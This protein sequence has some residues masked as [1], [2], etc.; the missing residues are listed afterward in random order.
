MVS[1]VRKAEL[2]NK[3]AA[4][5]REI[6]YPDTTNLI[7][8]CSAESGYAEVGDTMLGIPIYTVPYLDIRG[9]LLL[10]GRDMGWTDL[11]RKLLQ[12]QG[13]MELS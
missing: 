3:V 6:G 9:G 11:N 12:F 2:I 4:A 13:E 8:V 7:F 1:A 10:A 5:L